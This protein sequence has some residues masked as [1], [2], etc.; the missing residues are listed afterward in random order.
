MILIGNMI[1]V[2]Y[3]NNPSAVNY[4]MFVSVFAIVTLIYLVLIAFNDSFTGF[5]LI[6]VVLD[7]LNVLFFFCGGVTLASD[8]GV[9]SCDNQVCDLHR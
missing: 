2:S 1:D 9:H 8:L 4:A 5:A 3:G 6:P 7:A